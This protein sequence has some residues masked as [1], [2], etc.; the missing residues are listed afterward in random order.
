MARVAL[1][2]VAPTM[3]SPKSLI[4]PFELL[5]FVKR[6]DMHKLY[7]GVALHVVSINLLSPMAMN[8]V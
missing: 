8:G 3:M 2:L 7:E 5:G 4:S 1:A 6:V